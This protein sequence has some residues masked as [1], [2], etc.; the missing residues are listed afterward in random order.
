MTL[1][2]FFKGAAPAALTTNFL[3]LKPVSWNVSDGLLIL[4]YHSSVQYYP[5]CNIES[6]ATMELEEDFV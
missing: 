3:D 2:I 4:V 1:R 5:L 6:F